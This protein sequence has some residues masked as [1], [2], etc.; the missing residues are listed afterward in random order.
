MSEF[1]S[2]EDRIKPYIDFDKAS[3]PEEIRQLVRTPD[4]VHVIDFGDIAEPDRPHREA[5]VGQ[6]SQNG[7]TSF[8][9]PGQECFLVDWD[10]LG[11]K[12]R[13]AMAAQWDIN[14]SAS[15]SVEFIRGFD[16]IPDGFWSLLEIVDWIAVPGGAL[17][18]DADVRS[19]L[20]EKACD[21]LKLACAGRTFSLIGA[22]SDH[23]PA[24][25]I[26]WTAYFD[27]ICF[28]LDGNSI[29]PDDDAAPIAFV[30]GFTP[31]RRVRA[32]ASD[33]RER[34]P[35]P[36][37]TPAAGMETTPP[38][39]VAAPVAHRGNRSFANADRAHFDEIRQMIQ[40]GAA[41]SAYGA[42]LILA[43]DGKLAGGGT[44]DSKAKRISAL[45]RAEGTSP[46]SR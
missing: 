24:R 15:E 9:R 46:D 27:P 18:D 20:I 37:A 32:L 5:V 1:Q 41:R 39:P 6:H 14:N 12:Q 3:L 21:E 22:Q 7:Q 44:P 23:E 29:E 34:W 43:N 16:A 11:P 13:L 33:V 4:E 28:F 31:W 19:A 42:G 30:Q 45:F 10:L 8:P 35:I 2:F 25:E 40:N 36:L 38:L 17:P 26:P